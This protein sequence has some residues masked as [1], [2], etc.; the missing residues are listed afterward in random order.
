MTLSIIIPCF[1]HGAFI[2]EAINS[3]LALKGIVYEIIIVNDGS[4]DAG[5]IR[6]IEELERAG[7]QVLSHTNHGLAYSRNRGIEAAKGT[8]ILPLDA[9]NKIKPEYV[10]KALPL[11]EGNDCDVVYAKPAFFGNVTRERLFATRAMNISELSMLNY[12][13]ACAIY[14]KSVWQQLNGYDRHMPFPGQEDW[15]FWI[16]AYTKN[17]RFRFIDEELFYYRIEANSMI[18]VTVRSDRNAANQEY[19]FHK[20][21]G[22]F[23]NLL[24]SLYYTSKMREYD[25]QHPFRTFVKYLYYSLFKRS[26]ITSPAIR[27]DA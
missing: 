24:V 26:Q 14:K 3:V 22:F 25:M 20:H 8:C 2:Q 12:I 13:D 5:T 19:I 1:N 23:R 10:Y 15:E 27:T 11:L 21:S 6:K 18:S 9:D 16:H 4:T 17:F 7:F